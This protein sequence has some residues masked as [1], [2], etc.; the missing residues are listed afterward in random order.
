MAKS[1][2]VRKWTLIILG[3]AAV[4][5]AYSLI[6]D[7]LAPYTPQAQIRAFVVGI[8]PEVAGRITEV[9][10]AD[11]QRVEAGQLLFRVDPENY[12]LAVQQAEAR[13]ASVGQSL[14][15]STAEVS[16]AEAKLAEAIAARDNV[17]EQVS[18]VMALVEKGIYSKARA[19]QAT[20]QMKTADAAV[21][22][23][24]S[25]IERARQNLGPAGEDNPQVQEAL[26]ALAKARLDLLRTDVLAPSDGLVTNL[27][28]TVGRYAGAGQPLLTFIDLRDYWLNAEFRENS[29][30]NMAAGDRA[31]IVL[32]VLP[33]RVFDATVRSI[34]WGVAAHGQSSAGAQSGTGDLPT[35]RNQS[36]WVRD[37]QR[38]PVLLDIATE[39]P[40]LGIRY[41]SQANVIVYA[42]DDPV[43]R[44]IGWLWI[45]LVAV[46]T[47]VI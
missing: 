7:R 14:G 29:L 10:V 46:L 1:N 44:A 31:E 21:R 17:R 36:G 47:Y 13:L 40:P 8:A 23:A 28:L 38:F 19:D 18:R 25:E 39:K 34:G 4:F 30:G 9:A 43:T 5:F 45:R 2:P 22:A 35:I 3:V 33:G 26:A 16:T 41:G 42:S 37:A 27:Q 32:D 12:R 15:A 20:A 11:N 6:S 24:E